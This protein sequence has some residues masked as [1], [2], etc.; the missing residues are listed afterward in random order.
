MG[1]LDALSSG[2]DA[3]SGLLAFLQSFTQPPQQ[4]QTGP[5]A[6]DMMT[7]YGGNGAPGQ[8]PI[9]TQTPSVPPAPIAAQAN[10]S[11]SPLDN[12]QW[13]AGPIGAPS[14][15]NAQMPQ[16]LPQQM[17]AQQPSPGAPQDSGILGHIGAALQSIGAP[18][19]LFHN[20]VTN[21]LTALVTGQTPVDAARAQ[22]NQIAN[23]TANALLKKGV[24]RDTVLAA[25]QPG[26]SEMLKTLVEANFKPK[27]PMNLGSGYV[28]RPGATKA[29]R[30]YE[31]DEKTPA[32]FV[33]DENT[34]QMHYVTGGP[35][36]PDYIQLAEA[37]KKDPNG[38]FPLGRGGELYKIDAN[39]QPV[40]VHKNEAEQP[41]A[42]LDDKTT[43]A[44]AS[45][46]LAGDKSVMQNL[47]R[48]AQ[49]AANIVKLRGEIYN[50]ANAQGLNGKDIV[51]NFNEQ[52][53]NLA[54]QRS[55]GTRAANISL[56]ANEANNMI[57]I[58]LKASDAVPRGEWMPWNKMVQAYQTG[59]S[60][61]ELA[62]FVAATNSLVNSY[63]RAVSP[64]GVPTDSMREHAY[65]MLNSAQ[66]PKAYQAVTSIMQDEMKAAMAAPAQV[67]KELRHDDD[68]VKEEAKPAIDQSAIEAE[69]KRRGLLK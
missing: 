50:Q 45:Q 11:P 24:D 32:G 33:K 19:S 23:I 46:Y 67:R 56:A 29:E 41:D 60:S 68:A 18:G 43:Q 1:L 21:P 15:A 8:A 57:P 30:L 53:G 38:V 65:S 64:S 26:N 16:D 5:L 42:T 62:R 47:G 6:P 12:A 49:G 4:G 10:A 69:M 37:K 22:Q 20:A 63:V 52:A 51:N 34:G 31:P 40:I 36:D 7:P 13:P 28:L 44:M 35:A 61:P 9:F 59:T 25:I 39:G 48:G 54:G 66:S 17:P 14:Q 2:S 55:I 58:A 3:N 27:D